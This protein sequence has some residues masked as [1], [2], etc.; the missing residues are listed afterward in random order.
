M[1]DI[2]VV[3]TA[4]VFGAIGETGADVVPEMAECVDL[5]EV[6][7]STNLPSTAACVVALE[8]GA[9]QL[10][11][12][13]DVEVLRM[14]ERTVVTFR[15][16]VPP[17]GVTVVVTGQDVILVCTLCSTALAEMIVRI[18]E[19]ATYISVVTTSWVFWVTGAITG[20]VAF[21]FWKFIIGMAAIE[22][23]P[24]IE[25]TCEDI[26]E[27]TS[28]LLLCEVAD[29]DR[30]LIFEALDHPDS[31][32][33]MADTD[34]VLFIEALGVMEE[35][36]TELVWWLEVVAVATGAAAEVPECTA[37]VPEST[38]EVPG[39]TAEVLGCTLVT[40]ALEVD[41]FV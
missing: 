19:P 33:N 41:D 20:A 22:A 28:F 38:A 27:D 18:G 3:T 39:C 12:I 14:V 16:G 2:S 24:F 11:Q 6:A 23:A 31:I 13:I 35:L 29:T 10:V 26:D 15:V 36:C 4:W 21:D 5:A 40:E 25:E 1:T 17:A 8:I 37:E 34:E 9:T 32:S 7:A 30:L